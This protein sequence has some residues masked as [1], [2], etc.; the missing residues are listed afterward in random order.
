MPSEPPIMAVV[1]PGIISSNH[2]GNWGYSCPDF[3][4]EKTD[5]FNH[6]PRFTVTN[7]QKPELNVRLYGSLR[8]HGTVHSFMPLLDTLIISNNY[9]AKVMP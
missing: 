4:N 2:P 8:G 6:L 1:T 9:L 3:T 7:E 5:R